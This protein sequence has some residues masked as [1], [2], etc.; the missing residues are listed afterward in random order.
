MPQHI[1]YNHFMVTPASNPS[2]SVERTTELLEAL[3][4]ISKEAMGL[5]ARIADAIRVN[6]VKESPARTRAHA[7]APRAGARGPAAIAA[8]IA[9]E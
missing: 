3:A 1:P 7:Y 8:G 4:E 6:A 2:L 9:F 5:T